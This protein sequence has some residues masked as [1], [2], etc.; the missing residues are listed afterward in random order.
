MNIIGTEKP[1]FQ[2]NSYKLRLLFLLMILVV[3]SETK[4]NQTTQCHLYLIKQIHIIMNE[5][6]LLMNLIMIFYA[7]QHFPVP[8]MG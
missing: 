2:L 8:I 7:N 6:Q 4:A 3:I 5:F 1:I